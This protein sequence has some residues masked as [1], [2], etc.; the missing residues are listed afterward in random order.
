MFLLLQWYISLIRTETERVVQ[1][2]EI[3]QRMPLQD[4]MEGLDGYW[5]FFWAETNF[6]TG[7][8]WDNMSLA[9][10]SQL[11]WQAIE[12]IITRAIQGG[13]VPLSYTTGSNHTTSAT[14]VGPARLSYEEY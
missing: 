4:M 7:Q 6:P 14:K 13:D 5:G 2:L 10:C 1:S 11:E 9:K 12:R 8:T 3:S